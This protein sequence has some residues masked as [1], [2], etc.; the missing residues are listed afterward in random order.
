MAPEDVL[1]A[2]SPG[3]WEAVM[4]QLARLH[5]CL[6][7]VFREHVRGSAAGRA[8]AHKLGGAQV[9]TQPVV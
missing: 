2:V 1:T 8:V 5:E 3:A 9:A 4:G 6:F 7:V